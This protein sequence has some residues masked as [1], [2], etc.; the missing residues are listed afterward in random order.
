[1]VSNLIKCASLIIPSGGG[2]TCSEMNSNYKTRKTGHTERIE[3]K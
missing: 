3:F 1:M 2:P